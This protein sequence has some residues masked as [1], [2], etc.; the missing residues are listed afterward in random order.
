M[1][2]PSKTRVLHTFKVSASGARLSAQRSPVGPGA[3][4][5]PTHRR[6][7]LLGGQQIQQ[8]AHD[9]VTRCTAACTHSSHGQAAHTMFDAVE[10]LRQKLPDVLDAYYELQRLVS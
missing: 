9:A 7:P 5:L 3:A 2:A 6:S 10:R 1:C 4:Q 8:D